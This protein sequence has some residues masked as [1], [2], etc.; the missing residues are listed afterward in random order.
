[1]TRV[2]IVDDS[3]FMRKAI[4]LMLAGDARIEV[5]GQAANGLEG[6]RMARDLKP[7]VVTMDVEM[8]EMD[9]L[10]SL[11]RIMAECPTHVIMISSLTTE[12]SNAALTALK[13]GAADVMA[14]DASHVSLNIV[15]L[16]DELIAKVVALGMARRPRRRSGADTLPRPDAG[17]LK[18][19]SGQ[20][21]LLAIG[22]STGGPPVLE[23]ILVG[24]PNPLGAAVVVAQHMPEIFTKSMAERLARVCKLKVVHA[25]SGM[26]VERETVYISPGGKNTRL[27]R[28]AP[29]RWRLECGVE[30]KTLY[31]PSVDMLFQ[32]A[33]EVVGGRTLGVVLTGMGDDGVRGAKTLHGKGGVILA[34][35]EESCV[36]YGMPRAVTINGLTSASL[37][38]EGLLKSI[39]SMAPMSFGTG[40]VPARLAG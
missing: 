25:E 7:D 8:P 28:A 36:V 34:Q 2:L 21:D 30:P 38:P 39:Q 17:A 4:A 1:M 6:L 5:V 14:K 40:Q 37:S 32:S 31:M 22:S 13:A 24:L 12:G 9:G 20:F 3:V 18:F 19:R 35:N 26:T 11:R 10:T 16:K 27:C 29:G 33:A 15:N 23:S